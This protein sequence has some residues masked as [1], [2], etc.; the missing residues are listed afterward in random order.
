MP[1]GEDLKKH[2]WETRP[3]EAAS[4]RAAMGF[5]PTGVSVV[6]TGTGEGTEAMTAN[7]VLSVSLDPLLFLVSIHKDAR[8][9]GRIREEGFYAVSLLAADQEGL[10]RLFSSPERSSGLPAVNSLG[11]GFGAT[12]APLAAGAMAAI[13]CELETVYPGGDHGLFLGRVVAVHMGDSRKGPLV[14]HEGSYPALGGAAQRGGEFGA[15]VDSVRG[16][17]ARMGRRSPRGGRR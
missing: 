8:L 13:E 3:A 5:F 7:A 4:L 15:F 11:G 14:F 6:T 16:F 1:A 12:G 9:N 2:G 17:D 10:S